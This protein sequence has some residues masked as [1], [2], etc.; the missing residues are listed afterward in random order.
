[1]VDRQFKEAIGQLGELA[2]TRGPVLKA[3]KTDRCCP[4]HRPGIEVQ[5]PFIRPWTW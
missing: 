3:S 1:M 2:E 5:N 4:G